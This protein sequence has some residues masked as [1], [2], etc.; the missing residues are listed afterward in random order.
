MCVGSNLFHEMQNHIHGMSIIKEKRF[1]KNDTSK[2]SAQDCKSCK[3]MR[4]LAI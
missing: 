3:C 2:V 1:F 4:I